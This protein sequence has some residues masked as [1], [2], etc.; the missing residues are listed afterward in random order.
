MNED[1]RK[2]AWLAFASA[3]IAGASADDGLDND[4]IVE[5]AEDIADDMLAAY[6]KRFVEESERPRRSRRKKS[7]DGDEE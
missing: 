7:K 5:F 4:E 6:E 3:A 1:D 2:N